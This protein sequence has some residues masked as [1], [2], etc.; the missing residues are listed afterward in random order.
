MALQRRLPTSSLWVP[1]QAAA[2][3]GSTTTSTSTSAAHAAGVPVL[4]VAVVL[5]RRLPAAHA[6][7]DDRLR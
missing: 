5:L 7:P 6:L 2:A 1:V 4:H 3:A